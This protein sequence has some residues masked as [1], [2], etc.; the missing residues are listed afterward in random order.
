MFAPRRLRLKI[1]GESHE[2]TIENW[3]DRYIERNALASLDPTLRCLRF[4]WPFVDG[5]EFDRACRVDGGSWSERLDKGEEKEVVI[6]THWCL[7]LEDKQHLIVCLLFESNRPA[8]IP[9]V[10]SDIVRRGFRL[11]GVGV[12]RL[13]AGWRDSRVRRIRSAYSR[14]DNAAV[15]LSGVIGKLGRWTERKKDKERTVNPA[16]SLTCTFSWERVEFEGGS[17]CEGQTKQWKY[18]DSS[19]TYLHVRTDSLD[20]ENNPLAKVG[21]ISPEVALAGPEKVVGG[22]RGPCLICE[23]KRSRDQRAEAK[24]WDLPWRGGGAG[25]DVA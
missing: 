24:L 2:L 3:C 20:E 17:S 12:D 6:Y 10:S 7:G 8:A 16:M 25:G 5:G 23:R 14:S 11:E 9:Q 15:N 13:E 4:S 1:L 21:G 18:C 22:M 19:K